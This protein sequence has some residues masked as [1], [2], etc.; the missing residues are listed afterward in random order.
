MQ[1]RDILQGLGFGGLLALL[2]PPAL[3][4]V[5]GCEGD[6]TPLQF[7][8][9]TTPDP[10]PLVDELAKYP[11]CPYCG[12]DRTQWHHSRHLVHY[13]DGRVDATCSIH[14]TA[15]SL[16]INM[17]LGPKAIYAADFGSESAIKPLIDVSTAIYLIGSE[18][19]GTMSARSKMAFAELAILERA[20]AAHGGERGDFDAALLAAYHDMAEDTIRIRQRRAERRARA[21]H[22]APDH[23]HT[24]HHH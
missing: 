19:P 16:A 6:G 23:E 20:L 4:G 3:A 21:Q 7:M 22:H 9:R 13:D 24:P 1:R 12:M 18:L 2:A 5:Q 15:I 17:D 11:R 14:C 8:P 10:E